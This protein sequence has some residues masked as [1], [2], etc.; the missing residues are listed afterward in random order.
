MMFRSSWCAAIAL[1]ACR[2]ASAQTTTTAAA[3][4][5]PQSSAQTLAPSSNLPA[6]E[7]DVL[8]PRANETYNSTSSLPIVFAF[9]NFTAAAELG[10]FQFM[11]VIMPYHSIEKPI[12]GGVFEDSWIKSFTLHNVSTFTKPDGSAYVLTNYTNPKEWDH[13]PNYGG[14]AYA[15]QW[16]IQW[17]AINIQCDHPRPAIT[18]SIGSELLFTLLPASPG[19]W[20]APNPSALGNVTDNCGQLGTFAIIHASDTDVCSLDQLLLEKNGDPCAIKPDG[21]MVSSMS[22]TVESL[23]ASQSL[24]TTTPTTTESPA[25]SNAAIAIGAPLQLAIAAALVLGGWEFWLL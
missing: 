4:F 17:D 15:L 24:A 20:I 10:P 8:F 23:S 5:T 11:W 18:P 19:E 6:F 16:Y 13:G 1:A 7:V 21:P 12:P 25:T 14:T 9:Q 22:S 2:L 3:S